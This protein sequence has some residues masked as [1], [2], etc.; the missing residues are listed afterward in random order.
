[1]SDFSKALEKMA[2]QVRPAMEKALDRIAEAVQ[3]HAKESK[4]YKGSALRSSI[5]ISKARLSR[6]VLAD[7]E[8]AFWVEE[9]NNQKGPYIYP[10]KAK[11]LRFVSNGSVVFAKRVRAHGPLPF[12]A[13]AV[14]AVAPQAESIVVDELTKV[15]F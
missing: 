8:Y 6:T 1:M 12:M 13:Q 15:F 5:K 14:A 3:K 2:S 4:L 7:K 11:V 10:R 9:G